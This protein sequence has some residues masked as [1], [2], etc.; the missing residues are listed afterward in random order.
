[1]TTA[2]HKR[3]AAKQMPIVEPY[4]VEIGTGW[5]V[6]RNPATRDYSAVITRADIGY[7]GS[8]ATSDAA[9]ELC[10]RTLSKLIAHNQ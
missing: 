4:A 5:Q 9:R 8:T 1:M 2:A 6:L 10:Y 3:R 7:I